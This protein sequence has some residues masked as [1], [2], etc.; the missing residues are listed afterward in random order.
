MTPQEAD[1]LLELLTW[2][3][4]GTV[5]NVAMTAG[6]CLALLWPRKEDDED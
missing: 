2:I 4:Y 6:L 5:A 3:A 1:A